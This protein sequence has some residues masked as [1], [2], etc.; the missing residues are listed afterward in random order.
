MPPFRRDELDDA[1]WDLWQNSPIAGVEESRVLDNYIVR[2]QSKD[3]RVEQFDC[4]SWSDEAAMHSDFKERLAF[5]D[6]YGGNLDALNDSIAGI[7][8][9]P[10]L[11]LVVVLRHFTS[12][13]SN[14]G[15]REKTPRVVLEIL[16]RTSRRYL[17]F[18]QR[19]MAIAQMEDSVAVSYQ[20]LA[21]VHV[22]QNR[23]ERTN[24]FRAAQGQPPLELPSRNA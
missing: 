21:G 20:G 9:E 6:Y 16:A 24:R 11:G 14:P 19:F 8:I 22:A 10:R 7:T 23:F 18:G 5:P 3:Y 15:F 4:S 17:L 13:T 2:L 1:D 12:I